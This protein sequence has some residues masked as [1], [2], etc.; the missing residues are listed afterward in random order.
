MFS[1]CMRGFSPGTPASSHH[2]RTCIRLTGDSKI[3]LR[4]EWV[5]GCL[6]RLS[7]SGPVMDW[8]PV[9]GVPRL[10][11][12][13]R[14]DRL[15]PPCNPTDGLSGYRKWM[16]GWI[17]IQYAVKVSATVICSFYIVTSPQQNLLILYHIRGFSM[18]RY[19]SSSVCPSESCESCVINNRRS[20][21]VSLVMDQG[22]A[23]LIR[24]TTLALHK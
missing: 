7:L 12:N 18:S 22:P 4:S 3:V 10:S 17:D 20:L 14:W 24:Q 21:E 16:A 15:Q 19:I 6:S 8:R 13:D 23:E 11:P 5:C 1:P 9:Q 2:P